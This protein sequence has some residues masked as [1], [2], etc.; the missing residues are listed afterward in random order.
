MKHAGDLEPCQ[1]KKAIKY[2]EGMLFFC[3]T[4]N[5]NEA[6][7]ETPTA[8]NFYKQTLSCM[9]RIAKLADNSEYKISILR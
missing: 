8:Y 7:G 3:L 2:L 4:A 1:V 9:E 6:R 5:L